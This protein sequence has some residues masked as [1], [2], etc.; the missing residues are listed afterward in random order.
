MV[1][2]RPRNLAV[3]D[4]GIA[5]YGRVWVRTSGWEISAGQPSFPGGLLLHH[6]PPQRAHSAPQS[7]PSTSSRAQ[8]NVTQPPPEGVALCGSGR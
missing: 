7:L 4:T 8:R 2:E 6:H 1:F 5:G 3:V